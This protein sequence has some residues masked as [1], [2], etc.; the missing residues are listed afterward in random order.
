MEYQAW[1]LARQ[2]HQL[3]DPSNGRKVPPSEIVLRE[4]LSDVSKRK[5]PKEPRAPEPELSEE[6]MG[7]EGK[8]YD[9]PPAQRG[10]H[11]GTGP[12]G[13]LKEHSQG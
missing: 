12:K 9:K 2:A 11:Q 8:E 6:E 4:N 3:R 5:A 13:P 10:T 1:R 7:Q